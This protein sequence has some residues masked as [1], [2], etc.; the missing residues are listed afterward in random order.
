MERLRCG[1]KVPALLGEPD[2]AMCKTDWT[3]YGHFRFEVLG[4][5]SCRQKLAASNRKSRKQHDVAWNIRRTLQDRMELILGWNHWQAGDSEMKE[6][7]K[8]DLN[9]WSR[10]SYVVSVQAFF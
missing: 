1:G 7:G 4:R 8:Q 9:Q 10:V 5:R 6:T 3:S 2:G